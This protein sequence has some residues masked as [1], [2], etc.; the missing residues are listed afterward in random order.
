[1]RCGDWLGEKSPAKPQTGEAPS[2]LCT[3]ALAICGYLHHGWVLEQV[4]HA[5]AGIGYNS[6]VVVSAKA[7]QLCLWV[8]RVYL[9]LYVHS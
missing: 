2:Y 4:S 9:N 1:M 7:S 8:T 6:Y 5:K 3:G